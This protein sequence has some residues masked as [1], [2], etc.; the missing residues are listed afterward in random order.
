MNKES[1]PGLVRGESVLLISR[2]NRARAAG[3]TVQ[4]PEYKRKADV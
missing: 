1:G 2:R 4:S 3:I